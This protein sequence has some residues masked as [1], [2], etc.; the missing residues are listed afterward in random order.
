MYEVILVDLNNFQ[1]YIIY[2]IKQ[3]QLLNYNVT[4]IITDNLIS[5]FENIKNVKLILT[6]S[7]TNYN[8]NIN[9]RLDNSFRNGFWKLCSHRLFYL[10]SYIKD[11]NIINSFHIENDIMIY[12]TIKSFDMSKIWITMDSKNRCIPGIIFIPSYDKLTN[13]IKNY[14]NNIND[15][16]N[17]ALFYYNNMD[18]CSTFPIIKQ[19]IFYNKNDMFNCNFNNFNVIFDAAAI[20]QYL[21]GVDPKNNS[22]DTR[23]FIN[24]TCVVDYSKYKFIW[25]FDSV[26]KLY[27]PHII[28]DN[29]K[30]PIMNLHIHSKNLCNFISINPNETKLITIDFDFISGELFQNIADIYLGL[31]EDFEYNP[32]IRKQYSK[33]VDI[34]KINSS[35]NNPYIIFCYSHRTH[36]LQSN[37]QHFKNPFVLITHNSDEI[38]NEKYESLLN[39]NKIIKWYAQNINIKHH[40]L[41]LL[42]I[43]IANSMWPHGNKNIL[44]SVISNISYKTKDFYFFFNIN[45]NYNERILCKTE[46][47]KKGLIFGSNIDYNSYLN[48][49]AGYKFAICPSG[50]GI[51]CHRTWECYYLG[52]IPILLKSI[53]TEQLQM[54]LPCI[55]LNKWSDFDVNI[56]NSYDT[57]LKQLQYKYISLNY[58]IQEI[59]YKDY[60]LYMYN[61][62]LLF[63]SFF[64]KKHNK[65]SQETLANYKDYIEAGGKNGDFYTHINYHTIKSSLIELM[66]Q[67][68]KFYVFV[69]TGCAAHGTKSTLLW[70]KFVNLFD[71]KVISVDLNNS[72][73]EYTNSLTSNK[74]NVICSDSLLLLPTLKDSIDFLYLD[75]YDVDFLNPLKSAEHHL[76]EFNSVKKLLHKGSIVLINDTP[77]SPKWL[78]DGK[79]NNLYNI[80][81]HTFNPNMCGKGSLVNKELKKMGAKKIMHQYQCLWII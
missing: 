79:N 11:Y 7:L 73:V 31:T 77:C 4:V 44:K 8:Y 52:V 37:I 78:D 36:I 75:S 30:I 5:Y 80:L 41:H 13:L 33:L 23:G 27:Q 6:S 49:L 22:S 14:N 2:N 74:T 48:D 81:K 17:L 59:K 29:I 38:I 63:D 47:E 34:S 58:Y 67:N 25:K 1:E 54:I 15:M 50:N 9:S 45:T 70:D 12:N 69:E 24:E 65:T 10:Y 76:K 71:G 51:D 72:S 66:K 43:A 32:F 61:F 21:G 26:L 68:K 40:K 28:I 20:G 16:E 46:I 3:L 56:I 35:Y 60:G 42:P 62:N 55:L 39:S 19:N 64:E 53:F 57:L 18:I